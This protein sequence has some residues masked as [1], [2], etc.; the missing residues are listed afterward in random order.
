MDQPTDLNMKMLHKCTPIAALPAVEQITALPRG[1]V[2][3]DEIA[4]EYSNYCNWALK[5]Y[6]APKLT[7]EQ[8]ES[9]IAL[10][11]QFDEMSHPDSRLW[12]EDAMKSRPKWD[13]V[14]AERTMYFMPSSGRFSC[15]GTT[16]LLS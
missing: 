5:G 12:T 13:E 9:L 10:D 2:V 16:I 11:K 3:A 14:R 15:L 4:L 6:E 8:R 7:N 1:L